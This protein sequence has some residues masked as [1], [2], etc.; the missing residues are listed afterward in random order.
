MHLSLEG[1][2]KLTALRR[3][4]ARRGFYYIHSL[5]ATN[6]SKALLFEI[7]RTIGEG[8]ICAERRTEQNPRWKKWLHNESAGVT[9]VIL[10]L[11]LPCLI[12]K[13]G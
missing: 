4:E 11:I 7:W 9:G 12:I 10:P 8:G 13:N 2:I 1:Y 5:E 6:G 3:A